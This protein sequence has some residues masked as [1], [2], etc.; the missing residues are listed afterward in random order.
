[1]LNAVCEIVRVTGPFSS[2]SFDAG[3]AG[4]SA[5][6]EIPARFRA[7]AGRLAVGS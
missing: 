4:E 6:G 7:L 5:A 2:V 1:M 3:R